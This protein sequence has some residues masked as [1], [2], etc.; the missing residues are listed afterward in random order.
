MQRLLVLQQET[1]SPFTFKC[2]FK[3]SLNN[4]TRLTWPLLKACIV[5][6]PFIGISFGLTTKSRM[7][8]F[9]HFIKESSLSN[10]SVQKPKMFASSPWATGSNTVALRYLRHKEQTRNKQVCFSVT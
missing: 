5:I 9:S 2:C 7:F 8:D 3:S 6:G 4:V 1:C 10:N